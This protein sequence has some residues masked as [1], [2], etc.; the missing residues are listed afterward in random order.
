MNALADIAAKLDA[1]AIEL[2]QLTHPA[3]ISTPRRRR[4]ADDADRGE[5]ARGQPSEINPTLLNLCL[6][7]GSTG[8]AGLTQRRE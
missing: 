2:R 7:L 6:L 8:H 1:L 4:R 5:I 3:A